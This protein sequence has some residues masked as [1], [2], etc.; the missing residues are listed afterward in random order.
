VSEERNYEEEA[1]VQGWRPKEEFKGPEEKWTDA[2]TFVEKG[3]K[4]TGILKSR[5]D[6]Q[7]QQIA[8][9]RSANK[10]FGEYQQQLRESDRK[11]AQARIAEL[12]AKRAEAVTAGDG[13]EFTRTDQE[14]QRE[15]DNLSAPPPPNNE[16][17][18]EAAWAGQNTWYGRDQ[19]LT[20]FADG[21][22]G[23]V[24]AE[25]YNGQARLDE[26]ARR[27]KATFPDS[28]ENPN[29][30]RANGVE[31]GGQIETGNEKAHTYENLQPEDK[32][33]CDRFVANGI[34][35]QEDYV[36]NYEWE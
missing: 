30:S 36:K 34:T 2:Q 14:I 4:I 27:T 12:E 21:V 19:A 20:A 16:S 15:R 5:L 8:E 9:L 33:A 23:M 35:T 26:I 13:Q 7:D 32:A 25:G 29:K 11:K 28:F 31:Q 3:E 1:R 24:E 6:R 17:S 22:S 10:D 18:I